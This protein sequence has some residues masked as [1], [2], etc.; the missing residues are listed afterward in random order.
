VGP[1]NRRFTNNI[2]QDSSLSR[3]PNQ[4]REPLLS[5]KLAASRGRNS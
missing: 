5:R 3:P 4:D 1:P 2:D